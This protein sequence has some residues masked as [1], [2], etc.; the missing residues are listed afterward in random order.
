MTWFDQPST[1]NSDQGF[2][3]SDRGLLLADGVFTTALVHGGA[4]VFR[5]EHVARLIRD[6]GALG[7]SIEAPR[8]Q[9]A[10]DDNLLPSGTAALRLTVTRGVTSRGLAGSGTVAPTLLASCRPIE[11]IRDPKPLS[12]A[13][14][15]TRRNETSVTS[16]HKTLSYVDNIIALTEAKRTGFDD[17]VFLNGMAHVTCSTTANIFC[18]FG[19]QLLTPRL[20]DG[21]LDGVTRKFVLDQAADLGFHTITDSLSVADVQSADQVFLTNSLRGIVPVSKIGEAVFRTSVPRVLT[22]AW[23][24][25]VGIEDA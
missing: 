18:L 11:F 25:A 15:S 4:M 1:D 2:D 3:V 14:T 16:Q 20:E 24:Q 7:I 22:E 23:R 13:I 10:I 12:L 6:A 5:A 19:K 9:R 21:V 8:I 17:A